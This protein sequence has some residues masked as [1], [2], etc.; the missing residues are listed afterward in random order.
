MNRR[1]RK[2]LATLQF[3][4]KSA[5]PSQA[6]AVLKCAN[7]DLVGCLC[8]CIQNVTMG[9]V[10]IGKSRRKK[11]SKHKRR[12]RQILDKG[13]NL[14]SKRKLLVQSGGFLPLLLAPIIGIAGSLIGD[15]I[16]GAINNR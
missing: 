8:E 4:A 14:S 16:S 5:K 15:A 11:L 12:L 7:K 3:L 2:H 10:A 1:V 6:K 9:N 13:T